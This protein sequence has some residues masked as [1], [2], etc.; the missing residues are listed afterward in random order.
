MEKEAKNYGAVAIGTQGAQYISFTRD[1]KSAAIFI[2]EQIK[3]K[4]G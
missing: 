1:P 3:T 2:L 4:R